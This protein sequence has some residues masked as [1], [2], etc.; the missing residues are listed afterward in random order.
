[1]R[2]VTTRHRSDGTVQIIRLNAPPLEQLERHLFAVT[3][4][5]TAQGFFIAGYLPAQ[6]NAIVTP[7]WSRASASPRSAMP[8]GRARCSGD[9]SPRS[10]SSRGAGSPAGAGEAHLTQTASTSST[11]FGTAAVRFSWPSGVTRTSSSMRMPTPRIS[12]GAV[13]SSSA[14]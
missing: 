6:V 1:M 14:T 5:L 8:S 9:R 10:S 2:D 7:R 3:A 13:S 11:S 4:L 12:F